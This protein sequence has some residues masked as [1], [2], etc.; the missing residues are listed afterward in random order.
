VV[1]EAKEIA[2]E[3]GADRRP[4]RIAQVATLWESVPPTGYGGTERNVSYLTEELVR[5]GHQVTLFASGDSVTSAKLFPGCDRSLRLTKLATIG[6]AI[7]HRMLSQAYERAS[8]FDVIHAHLDYWSF[9]F[10]RLVST[11]S[12]T[13]I[14]GRLD[15]PELHFI[16]GE[17]RATPL[18]SV[19][20]AQ[21]APLPEMNWIA[22]IHHGLHRDLLKFN[23]EGGKYLA[24]LGR[25]SPETGVEAAIEVARKAGIPLKVAAKVD[26]FDRDYYRD[27]VTPLL[28][29]P[30]VEYIGEIDDS[31]KSDFLGNAIA[32][33]FPIDWPEPF[34]MVMIESMA[35][36]TPVIARPR[37]AVSEVLRDG[38]TA[39]IAPDVD[40]M[41]AAVKKIASLSRRRCREEFETR[42]TI[43]AVADQ[44]EAIYRSEMK[45]DPDP[46]AHRGSVGGLVSGINRQL[47]HR[48]GRATAQPDGRAESAYA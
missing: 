40:G 43:D 42:F 38:V 46:D 25:I 11:P 30:G 41:V 20:D 17:Y 35:C 16:Y 33:L 5:R 27:V 39:F 14:H 26:D 34:G 7:H 29:Q 12:V 28:A 22:T 15:I 18:V 48:I 8:Q 9:P 13:T 47:S 21:R 45:I 3:S 32:V 2:S 1:P 37:G 44:Y 19:S 31:Q 10:A 24:F 36:G 23:P 6:V 4:L